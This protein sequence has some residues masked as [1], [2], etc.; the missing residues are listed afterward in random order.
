M[1]AESVATSARDRL[2]NASLFTT[3]PL[4]TLFLLLLANMYLH[5]FFSRCS[6]ECCTVLLPNELSHPM[7]QWQSDVQAVKDCIASHQIVVASKVPALSA[8]DD[9]LIN[10]SLSARLMINAE[11]H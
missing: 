1:N 7:R 4:S 5:R 10:T 8:V 2:P 3:I 11:V 6:V 9:D